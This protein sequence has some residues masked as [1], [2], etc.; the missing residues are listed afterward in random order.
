MKSTYVAAVVIAV[1]IVT[2]SWAPVAAANREYQQLMADIRMLQEQTQ[3]LQLLLGN[4]TEALK[5]VTAKID[6]QSNLTRKAFADQK[7]LADTVAGDVRVVREKVDETNVRISSLSHE[8]EAIRGAIPPPAPPTDPSQAA[9]AP[10]GTAPEGTPAAGGPAGLGTLGTTMSPSRLYEMARADYMAGQYTLSV[11]GFESYLRSFP[12]SELADDAQFYI[13]D[14]YYADKKD[15]EA[16][17][18]YDKVIT[19]Y[20]AG[21]RVPEA[22]Y[23]RGL[24]LS[25]LKELERAKESFE[26]VV[27]KFPDHPAA[28]L[29]KQALER[30]TT[31]RP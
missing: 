7:V 22:Y 3:Q 25:N 23:K 2:A 30:M 5:T 14:A 24:V 26:V 29:A 4:V 16:F 15:K 6:D 1:A 21:N 12:K 19:D 17:A 11:Q 18:A 13:G 9:T 28:T 8:V 31:K 20:P 10:P 27:K